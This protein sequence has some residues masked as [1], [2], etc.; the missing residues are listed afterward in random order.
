MQKGTQKEMTMEVTKTVLGKT[1]T[2]TKK[3][4]VRIFMTDPM[5]VGLKKGATINMGNYSNVK[6]EVFINVPCYI[7]EAN[8]VFKQVASWTDKKLTEE[9]DKTLEEHKETAQNG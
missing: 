9:V 8:E 3:M 4:K 5:Y 7:E 6:V 2:K 1:T